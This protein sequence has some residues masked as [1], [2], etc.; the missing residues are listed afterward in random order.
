ME[1]RIAIRIAIAIIIA[2]IIILL[3]IFIFLSRQAPGACPPCYGEHG[4][5]ATW[6]STYSA[7]W[8]STAGPRE[9]CT[10][11]YSEPSVLGG[12]ITQINQQSVQLRDETCLVGCYT[13]YGVRSFLVG[14]DEAKTPLCFC[15]MNDCNPRGLPEWY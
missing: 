8:N 14:F 2:I 7:D 3:H 6:S 12:R 1:K 10:A 5:N 11:G 4:W 13:K 9:N 15:D